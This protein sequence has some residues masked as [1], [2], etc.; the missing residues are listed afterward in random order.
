MGY[1][2]DELIEHPN[3]FEMDIDE[4]TQKRF[5]AI[6]EVF[7]HHYSNNRIYQKYCN[8]HG[9]TPNDIKNHEDLLYIPLLPSDFF[10][11]ISISGKEEDIKKIASVPENAIV[12]YFT[13]SGTTGKA[14]KYPFDRDSIRRTTI[15]NVQINKH[16]GEI[17]EG[18]YMLMLTPPPEETTTGLVRGMYMSTKPI[19]NKDD[20]I[21]FGV[22]EG[23]IDTEYILSALNSTDYRPRHFFGPPFAYK[24]IAEDLI[25]EGKELTLDKDS[26][27]FTSGGWKRVKG[28][29]K[30]EELD[31]IISKSLG[32]YKE[33][34]RDGLGLTDIF[35]WLL[36]CSY[37][38]KH[39]PPWMYVSIRNPDNLEEEVGVGE[40]GLFS[41]L[42]PIIT[43]YPSFVITGDIGVLTTGYEEKCECGRIGP[44]VEHRRRAKGMAARGCA[45]VLEEVIA[46]MR[47]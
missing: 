3:P 46:L 45:L 22:R 2:C 42:T 38:R 41:F 10:K 11:E 25:E 44:T 27:A 35:S 36:E 12:T 6:K 18:S 37:R 4:A 5:K 9:I 34:I 26:K 31:E 30:R 39:V 1:I 28:E 24:K 15:S 17:N 13:T 47:K 29:V 21:S 7:T 16:I 23:K 43:S 19:L 32:I 33:N 40:E 20:Q 14:T 8:N